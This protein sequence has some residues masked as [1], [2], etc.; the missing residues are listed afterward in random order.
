MTSEEKKVYVRT[1][2]KE[3]AQ[4]MRMHKLKWY[5]KNRK[6]INMMFSKPTGL[7]ED[8]AD[9]WMDEHTLY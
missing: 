6:V 2:Q 7:A 1:W 9:V 5:Y 4:R 8:E 3:H